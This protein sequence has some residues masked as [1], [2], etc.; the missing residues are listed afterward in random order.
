M[1]R[2]EVSRAVR[3]IYIYVF[4]RQGVKLKLANLLKLVVSFGINNISSIVCYKNF[5]S[6]IVF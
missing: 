4:R 2:L 3:H 6:V 5:S 1:Q